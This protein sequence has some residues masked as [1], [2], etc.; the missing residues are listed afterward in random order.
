MSNTNQLVS[1]FV[2]NGETVNLPGQTTVQS[3]INTLANRD[4]LFSNPSSFTFTVTDGMVRFERRTGNK[5]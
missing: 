1:S 3:I 5:A 2:Y 4:P